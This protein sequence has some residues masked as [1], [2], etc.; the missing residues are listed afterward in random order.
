[1]FE[2]RN[3]IVSP[4]SG[5]SFAAKLQFRHCFAARWT[6]WTDV[7]QGM[8]VNGEFREWVEDPVPTK[9]KAETVVEK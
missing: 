2:L 8:L 9:S 7:P 5:S 3:V 1:M 4:G 6:E